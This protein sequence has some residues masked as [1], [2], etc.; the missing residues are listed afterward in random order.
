MRSRWRFAPI[1]LHTNL[2]SHRRIQHVGRGAPK[3]NSVGRS[4]A[5]FSGKG[6][7]KCRKSQL[8]ESRIR[9]RCFFACILFAAF[10]ISFALTNALGEEPAVEI[11]AQ[12]GTVSTE[13]QGSGADLLSRLP[14]HFSLGVH[15]G[16]DD[17][18]D[19]SGAERGSWFTNG[20]VSLSYD[21]PSERTRLNLRAGADLTYYPDET[22]GRTNDVNAYVDLSLTHSISTRL[23]LSASVDATYRTEPDFSSNVGV[24]NRRANYFHMLDS[25]S[26]EYHWTL[27]FSTVTSD[28]FRLV[29]Y[30]SSSIGASLNRFEDTIGEEFRFNLLRRDT[31]L[32]GE[33]RFEIVDYD[34]FPRDSTTNFAL[35]GVDQD[36]TPQLK[37]VVRGGATFRSY[38]DDGN[39][40]DPHFESSLAYTGAHHSTLSWT[41]SYGIEE[42]N[43]SAILSR[44]TFRTGLEL[45]YGITARIIATVNG[46]YHHDENQGFNSAG[47][48]PVSSTGGSPGT[49][50]S[51]FSA[52][53]YDVAV[54][55]RYVINRRFSFDLGV[56]RSV[57]SSSGEASP[58]YVRNRYSAGLT[59]TY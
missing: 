53:S 37:A 7:Q 10:Q 23:K 13:D 19:A 50:S 2:K 3:G 26:A 20:G 48:S 59:F 41:T 1:E 24:E 35:V 39:R 29:Q 36:F 14:F 22:M 27:R 54:D 33:Y 44:T 58:N 30:D 4:S 49:V 51:G 21:L 47:S 15:G 56:Q 45:K 46:Y 8:G 32:V 55:A 28:K 43:S 17:N 18:V 12:T 40:T 52:D 42:P 16:Y 57:I 9:R 38:N 5:L 34:S 11:V 31:T 6:W 25:L